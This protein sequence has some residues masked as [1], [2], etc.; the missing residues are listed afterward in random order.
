MLLACRRL[1]RTKDELS[2]EIPLARNV[3]GLGQA[4]VDQ[5]VVVLEV[6]AEAEGLKTSPDYRM[7][8]R[9][10]LIMVKLEEGKTYGTTGAWR[11]SARP[12]QGTWRRKQGTSRRR[13]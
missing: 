8:V 9:S 3:E 11:W 13:A 2:L 10:M 4:G 5:G 7:N 12:T 1:N 6:G